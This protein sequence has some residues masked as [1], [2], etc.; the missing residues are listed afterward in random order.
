MQSC[1]RV[2]D[3]FKEYEG[4][5]AVRERG[6][7]VFPPVGL[8]RGKGPLHRIWEWGNLG[9]IFILFYLLLLD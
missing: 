3:S 9:Q 5:L 7:R 6:S 1:P 4:P 8:E 2:S